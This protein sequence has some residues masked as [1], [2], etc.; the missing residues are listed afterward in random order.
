MFA[1]GVNNFKT[2]CHVI[3]EIIV[4]YIIYHEIIRLLSLF[5]FYMFSLSVIIILM[6]LLNLFDI[7]N[8]LSVS[9]YRIVYKFS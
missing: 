4:N 9:V 2:N 7:Q 5:W 3:K 8:M 6:L 1:R